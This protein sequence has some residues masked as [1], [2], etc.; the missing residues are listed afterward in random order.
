[1]EL[2]P[3]HTKERQVTPCAEKAVARAE[4]ETVRQIRQGVIRKKESKRE[5]RESMRENE[6]ED[7]VS[8]VR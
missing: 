5:M 4:S 2:N 7:D 3:Y 1:M 8:I 6:E